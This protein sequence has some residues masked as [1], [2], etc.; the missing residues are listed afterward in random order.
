MLGRVKVRRVKFVWGA[1]KA[2]NGRW[3][4]GLLGFYERVAGRHENAVAISVRGM[5]LWSGALACAAYLAAATA[6]FWVWER[7]PYSSLT[8]GDAV[9]YPMRR[10]A[11]EEKKGQAFITQGS[12]LFRARKY[13]DAATLLRLGLARYPRDIRGRLL[14]AQYYLLA[15]QRPMAMNLLVQGLTDEYPGRAYLEALFGAAEEG[16]DF[17]RVIATSERYLVHLRSSGPGRDYRWMVTRLFAAL[18]SAGRHEAALQLAKAEAPGELA[19][20]QEVLALLALKRTD[21]AVTAVENWRKA[22]GADLRA[23]TRIQVRTLREA[24]RFDDMEAAVAEL[25]A[26]SPSDPAPAVYGVVQR[27]MAGRAATTDAALEDYLF[28]F[29]GNPRNLILLAEPLGEIHDL[30]RLRRCLAAAAERGHPMARFNVLLVQTLV[31]RGEWAEANQLLASMPPETGRN[32]PAQE[33]WR[34]WMQAII[35]AAISQAEGSQTALREF[36]RRRPW[37]MQTYQRT[38]EALQLAGRIET[39]RDILALATG[40]FPANAWLRDRSAEVA[41]LI[42]V[43]EREVAMATAVALP[44]R[45]PGERIFF[46]QL[47]AAVK[48]RSWAE[49]TRLIREAQAARPA[50]AWVAA[51]EPAFR[52]AQ[53][54]IGQGANDRAGMITSTRLFLNGTEDRNQQALAMAR[55][56]WALGEKDAARLV[57]REVLMRSAGFPPAVRLLAE[58]DPKPLPTEKKAESAP[59]GKK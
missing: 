10:R 44:A 41:G 48:A 27:A 35:D 17:D 2:I 7:N 47:D 21:E 26:L 13:N 49:A 51:R 42:A 5:L 11:I 43:R 33:M 14:L 40:A 9:L 18:S 20:E 8:Y 4:L 34:S 58:W 30:P 25:R 12:D 19:R 38:I 3:H 1:S 57:V 53:A 50:P 6:L 59:G 28:R 29:G 45:L 31:Q 15:G 16:G 37:P 54:R 36:L 24:G 23:V 32:A 39:A 22:P 52:L 56:F 55:E 46:D